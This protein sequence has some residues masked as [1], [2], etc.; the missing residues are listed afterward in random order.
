M[1]AYMMAKY[2]KGKK[3]LRVLSLGTGRDLDGMEKDK[4]SEREFTKISAVADLSV[5]QFLTDYEQTTAT[6]IM[7]HLPILK[8][9]GDFLRVQVQSKAKLDSYTT[10]DIIDMKE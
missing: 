10:Q 4:A 2:L 5:I 6:H 9:T 7:K 1:Y 8:K 3:Q